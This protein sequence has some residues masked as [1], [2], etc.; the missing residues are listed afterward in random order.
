MRLSRASSW[1]FATVLAALSANAVLLVFITRSYDT[2]EATRVSRQ[3][4]LALSDELLQA[5]RRQL[6]PAR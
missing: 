5:C 6:I 1:F 2:L 4:A 3:G